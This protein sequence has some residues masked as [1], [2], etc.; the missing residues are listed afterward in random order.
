MS[1]NS[2]VAIISDTHIGAKNDSQH[3]IDHQA[4]F[5][6]DVFFREIQKRDIKHIIHLGDLLDRRRFINFK[7]LKHLRD[8][9]ISKLSDMGLSM[10]ILIGNHDTY[11]KNTNEL[12]SLNLILSGY[13]N[14]NVIDECQEV[15]Y[16]GTSVAY[17]PWINKQ[18]EKSSVNFINTTTANVL[19]GHLELRGFSIFNHD[20]ISDGRLDT[21][22]FLKFDL[23]LSGHYHTKTNLGDIHYVGA[24]YQT[25]WIDWGCDKGFHILDTNTLVLEFIKNPDELFINFLYDDTGFHSVEEL[26]RSRDLSICTGRYIRLKVVN[27]QKH[28]I[29]RYIE[30]INKLKPISLQVMDYYTTEYDPK[31]VLES[32]EDENYTVNDTR[33]IIDHAARTISSSLS[34]IMLSLYEEAMNS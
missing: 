22:P 27:S 9:F 3:I 10:D 26:L 2:K 17:V 1:S 15:D 19:F 16:D 29:D 24:P 14:I 18:N 13:D 33:D 12:N 23:V 31:L 30:E 34:P 21:K 28:L 7:V 25:T 4:K 20:E 11:F 8:N 5:F 6:N 32:I